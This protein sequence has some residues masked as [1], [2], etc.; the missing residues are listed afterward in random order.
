MLLGLCSVTFR[1]LEVDDL[2]AIAQGNSLHTIEWGADKHVR[3]DD[4]KL[5][6]E[7]RKKSRSAGLTEVSYG[8]YY[9]AGH[10]ENDYSF[11]QVLGAAAMLGANQIRVWAGKKGSADFSEADYERLVDDLKACC[12]E[13]EKQSIRIILEYHRNTYTDT[14]EN[15][16]K[17]LEACDEPNLNIGWQPDVGGSMEHHK[18][19]IETLGPWIDTIHV[20]QWDEIPNRYPLEDGLEVWQQYVEW[21]RAAGFKRERYLLEFV[22]DDDMVQF[23]RDVSTLRDIVGHSFL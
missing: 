20:F 13:A 1:D 14:P 17:L 19:S 15:A 4:L 2:L 5:A 16:R 11:T 6:A 12:K 21:L 18:H 23:S 10:P 22:K 8:S 3:P 7:V 9:R